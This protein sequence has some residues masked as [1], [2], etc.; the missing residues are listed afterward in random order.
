VSGFAGDPGPFQLSEAFSVDQFLTDY[1]QQKPQ[2]IRG[3]FSDFRDPVSGEELAGLAC[4]AEFESRLIQGEWPEKLQ[5]RQGPFNESDFTALPEANWTVLVQAVDQWLP[6]V[7]ALR[8][9]FAFIPD[10]R[11]DDVMVSYAAK[12][13][14]VGPHWDQYDV[15]LVQGS[16]RRRWR[17][18]PRCSSA[19][20][21]DTS[22]GLSLLKEFSAE[23][24]V[25]LCAGDA[26]YLP[27]RFSHWGTAID[28]G[29]CYSIGFRAPSVAEMIEGFSDA[30]IAR[31]DPDQR[32]EDPAPAAPAHPA[33]LLPEQL[34]AA[35]AAL[36][37]QLGQRTAFERWFGCHATQPRYPDQILPPPAELD[38]ASLEHALNTGQALLRHPG[39]RFAFM[40]TAAETVLC[41]VDGGCVELPAEDHQAVS[42][43]CD[44]SV[45]NAS[46]S[47]HEFNTDEGR[48]MV[49]LLVN[50]GSL[51]LD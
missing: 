2:V 4:E 46:Q 50:Q 3:L 36:T 1:W 43:L 37:A 31:S 41:F 24:D 34:S 42:S 51:V 32:Y 23:M 21:L 22:T 35:F 10:W 25:E 49:L 9:C 27:P 16:G 13:G 19:T 15:F 40:T 5:L 17:V 39:S 26:L 14:S 20:A 7:A 11:L 45:E 48:A 47:V 29:L 28:P 8:R 6:E 38:F 30:L 12:G 44:L 33:Q 18:G